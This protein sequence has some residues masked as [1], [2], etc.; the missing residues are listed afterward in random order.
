MVASSGY[1]SNY[2][3]RP[4][5]ECNSLLTDEILIL[6]P[7]S[8]TVNESVTVVLTGVTK[9]QAPDGPRSIVICNAGRSPLFGLIPI[10][11][12]FIPAGLELSEAKEPQPGLEIPFEAGIAPEVDVPESGLPL[13]GTLNSVRM[14]PEVEPKTPPI[15]RG[16]FSAE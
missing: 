3:V 13:T 10:K 1:F 7:E 9:E 16:C 4:S 12:S 15:G 8:D 11:L 6:L 5:T 14:E 2:A